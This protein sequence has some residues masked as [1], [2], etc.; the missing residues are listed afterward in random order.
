M[1]TKAPARNSYIVRKYCLSPEQADWLTDN[2]KQRGKAKVI[3]ELFT[4]LQNCLS[5]EHMRSRLPEDMFEPNPD[6]RMQY[7]PYHVEWTGAG[8]KDLLEWVE[9]KAVPHLGLTSPAHLLRLVI[10]KKRGVKE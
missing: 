2:S 4:D 6:G 5:W 10:D 9:T 7:L 3:R 1:E 8:D